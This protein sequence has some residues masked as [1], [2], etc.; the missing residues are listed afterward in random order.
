V[1]Q[2]QIVE[3]IVQRWIKECADDEATDE[4]LVDEQVA[5]GEDREVLLGL[6]E[7]ILQKTGART[8]TEICRGLIRKACMEESSPEPKRTRRAGRRRRVLH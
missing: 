1:D 4:E 7:D 2:F 6:I 8:M 5:E 3:I